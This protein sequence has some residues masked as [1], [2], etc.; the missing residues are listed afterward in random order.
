MSKLYNEPVTRFGKK[1]FIQ[2]ANE[3]SRRKGTVG[4]FR[5]W[6]KRQGYSKVTTA[7]INKG[8]KSKSL[9]TRRRAVFAQN[10]RPKKKSARFGDCG[11]KRQTVQFGKAK[12]G[13]DS[14]ISYLVKLK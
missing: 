12:K 8:K 2:E 6:C 9:T 11:C 14:D 3:R 10:I 1:K 4:S 7:C 13:I 5:R